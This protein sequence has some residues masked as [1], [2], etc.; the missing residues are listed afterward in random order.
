MQRKQGIALWLQS[1]SRRRTKR[2]GFNAMLVECVNHN[3]AHEKD[4]FLRGPLV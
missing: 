1:K 4:L 2:L 3:I